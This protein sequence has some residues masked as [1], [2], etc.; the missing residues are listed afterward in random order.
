MRTT[1]IRAGL[2]A[3]AAVVGGVLWFTLG[4]GSTRAGGS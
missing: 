3:V 2:P 1:L 4:P